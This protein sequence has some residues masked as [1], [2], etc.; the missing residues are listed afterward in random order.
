MNK[1]LADLHCDTVLQVHRGYDIAVKNKNY[2]I[3]IPRL[4]EGGVTF[5][6]FA[7][8]IDPG[9]PETERFN[10]AITL[11]NS[12]SRAFQA[13]DHAI[14]I[15]TNLLQATSV[16]DKGKIAALLAIENG[17]AIENSLEKLERLFTAGIR[18]MTL[19]HAKSHEWCSSSSD[20]KADTYGLTRFGKDVVTKMNELGMI[21]DLSHVSPR[22]F[23]GVL[24]LSDAP[25]LVSHSNAYALCGHDRNLTDEQLKAL[26]EHGGLIGINFCCDF[27]SETYRLK[28]ESFRG[29][30]IKQLKLLGD[31]FHSPVPEEQFQRELK[32]HEAFIQTWRETAQSDSVTIE[33]AVDHIAYIVNL[34]GVDY[35]AFGSDFDGIVPAPVGLED[36]SRFPELLNR[37]KQKGFSEEDLEKISWK[38]FERVFKQICG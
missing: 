11:I 2:H 1:Y 25:V 7:I 14:E 6:A 26:A 17:M 30:H 24:E 20:E 22:A 8:Y 31:M 35:V 23:F 32:E 38:N 5:Q 18:Y 4:N 34:I 33:H 27:L 36:C 28:T 15:V 19:T 9:W 13:N 37:L 21:V 3:D 10:H 16:M 29:K 12:L